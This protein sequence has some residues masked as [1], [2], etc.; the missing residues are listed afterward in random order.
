MAMVRTPPRTVSPANPQ[1]RTWIAF[2]VAVTVGVGVVGW[3]MSGMDVPFVT[4]SDG[5]PQ[6]GGL[7]VNGGLEL[8]QVVGLD[9]L[10]VVVGRRDHAQLRRLALALER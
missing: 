2:S 9:P 1:Q 7:L 5:D 10:Q 4:W 3:S 6:A 8:A